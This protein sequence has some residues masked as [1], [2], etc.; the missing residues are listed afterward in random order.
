MKLDP[1]DFPDIL[2]RLDLLA[3]KE[4]YAKIFAKVPTWAV[5]SFKAQGFIIEAL[6]PA[7]LKEDTDAYFMSKFLDPDRLNFINEAKL[8]DLSAL[9]KENASVAE[10]ITLDNGYSISPLKEENANQMVEVFKVVFKTYP[11]P[12]HDAGY[13][14]QAM[15]DHVKFFGVFDKEKLVAIS[16]AEV[17]TENKN[18][19]MTDFATLPDYRGKKLSVALLQAMEEQMKKDKIKTVYTIARLNSTPM[20]KTFLKQQYQYGGTLIN[21]TNISGNIE[22]MNVL[23]K[24]L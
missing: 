23:Y 3:R 2:N 20:N 11:F 6:I 17:D 5:P 7:F 24:S 14:K 21:N 1:G 16:S 19:E 15:N 4:D 10:N 13:L 8:N 18:A 12:I 9:L 22:S